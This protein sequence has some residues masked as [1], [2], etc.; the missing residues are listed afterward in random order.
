MSAQQLRRPSSVRR[1]ERAEQSRCQQ[2]EASPRC[3]QWCRMRMEG[4]AGGWA[5]RASAVQTWCNELRA[6]MGI[7]SADAT[8][9]IKWCNGFRCIHNGNHRPWLKLTVAVIPYLHTPH[10]NLCFFLLL[11]LEKSCHC[12]ADL[13]KRIKWI[14][15]ALHIQEY[16]QQCVLIA[17]LSSGNINIEIAAIMSK[18]RCVF[19]TALQR[20]TLTPC[21]SSCRLLPVTNESCLL[22]LNSL[23]ILCLTGVLHHILM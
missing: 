14:R 1:C 6:A 8:T 9:D 11:C 5:R 18:D 4:K 20:L 10:A 7:F 12:E 19:F 23:R 2:R 3:S 15:I 21:R 16:P 17:H 22:S 13:R